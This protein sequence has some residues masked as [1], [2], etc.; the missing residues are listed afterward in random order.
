MTGKWIVLVAMVLFG[1]TTLIADIFYGESSLR[2]LVKKNTEQVVKGYKMLAILVVIL[3][4]VLSLPLL[5][6]FVDLCAAFL[7]FFNVIPLAGLF[8]YVKYVMN[9]YDKQLEEKKDPQW[10]N[11]E[12][13]IKLLDK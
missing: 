5:W 12:E 1:F 3:G 7:V 10:G 8:K 13:V 11:T 2:F 6:T 4:S 9:D